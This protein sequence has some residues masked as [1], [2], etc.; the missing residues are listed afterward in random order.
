[1][2]N[3]TMELINN[4]QNISLIADAV[5]QAHED[6][7]RNQSVLNNLNIEKNKIQKSLDNIMKAIESG[8]L[9]PKTKERLTTLET[10]LEIVNTKILSEE[11]KMQNQLSKEK[12]IAFL[13]NSVLNA[14]S[15]VIDTLIQKIIL[16]DDRIEIFYN[17][18]DYSNPDELIEIHRDLLLP[19][20]K[21][22]T[23]TLSYFLFIKPIAI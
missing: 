16:F 21:K 11:C 14:P 3:T 13:T 1:M 6:R 5:M 2:L 10:E 23:V 19:Q 20:N 18:I 15:L 4:P 12:V 17:Y 7:L 8:I 22:I 9:T